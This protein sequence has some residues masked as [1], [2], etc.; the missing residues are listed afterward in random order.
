MV[1]AVRKDERTATT[2]TTTLSQAAVENQSVQESVHRQTER[3]QDN[4]SQL[5]LTD[6]PSAA[7]I[8]ELDM[9]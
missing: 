6:A 3:E 8:R 2:T 9:T 7:E 5:L 1:A 4:P